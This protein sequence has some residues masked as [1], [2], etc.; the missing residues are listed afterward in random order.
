M[1][2]QTLSFG[3]E[4]YKLPSTGFCSIRTNQDSTGGPEDVAVLDA[5]NDTGFSFTVGTIP[6]FTSGAFVVN[7]HWIAD[8]AITNSAVW[9][10]SVRA[11]LPGTSAFNWITHAFATVQTATTAAKTTTRYP[12][13][14]SITCASNDSAA[15]GW[16]VECKV[17]RLGTNGSDNMAGDAWV[18]NTDFVYTV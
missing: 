2:T 17:R 13:V 11:G 14:T 3:A 9:E 15:A 5:A 16:V 8:S 7:I 18:F 6:G 10:V 4:A 1:A 12:Q